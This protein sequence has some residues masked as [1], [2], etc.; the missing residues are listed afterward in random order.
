MIDFVIDAS[1][2]LELITGPAPDQSLRRTALTQQGAAPELVDLEAANV[3]RRAVLAGHV[4]PEVG[5]ARLQEIRDTPITRTAHRPLLPRTW[6]LRGA[7][8]AYDAAYVA[9]AEQ[10]DVPLLTCDAKLGGSNGHR[11]EIVVYPRS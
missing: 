4:H 3:L 2:L 9:L 5:R 10:F 11:A 1:A 6:E 7:I 8:T